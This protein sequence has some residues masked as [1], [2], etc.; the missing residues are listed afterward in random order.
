MSV[1]KNKTY[2]LLNI[3]TADILVTTIAFHL[4]EVND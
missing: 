1:I 2:I 4:E 3:E